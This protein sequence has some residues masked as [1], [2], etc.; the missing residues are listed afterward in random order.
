[1]LLALSLAACVGYRT[2]L[3][4]EPGVEEARRDAAVGARDA[5]RDLGRPDQPPLSDCAP[6][7]PYVLVL[8][9]DNW[10]YRFDA[11]TL[12]LTALAEVAC[13]GDLNSMTVS[14]IGPA[15]ISSQD[16]DLCRVDM[17]TFTASPT[18]FD[19]REVGEDAFGMA[20]LPDTTPAGQTL[21]IASYDVLYQ[22]QLSRIDLGTYKLTAIGPILPIVGWAELTAGPNGELYG[23][24]VDTPTSLLLTI[25]PKT[26]SAIDVATVPAGYNLAA[27]FALV[28]WQDAFYL[29]IGPGGVLAVPG[30]GQSEK[31]EVFRYR[32]G[33]AQV[34]RLGTLPVAPIGAGV[35]VCQ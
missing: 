22:N 28:Y 19:P 7:T 24:A 18:S 9:A 20:L 4:D 17:H 32:K 12:A 13:G 34:Q 15:Y 16:G 31:A 35:A 11:A 2:P 14:P 23:F 26:G 21:F 8:G 25:D 33:D 27:A 29:F 6:G 1:M 5:G 10:L 3:L 30:L